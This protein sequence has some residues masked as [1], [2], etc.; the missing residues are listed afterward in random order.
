MG[1]ENSLW[2][3][4]SFSPLLRLIDTFFRYVNIFSQITPSDLAGLGAPLIIKV[5]RHISVLIYCVW[6]SKF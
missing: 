3:E 4:L 6:I 2:T 5:S 1:P